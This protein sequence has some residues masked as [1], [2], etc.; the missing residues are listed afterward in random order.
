MK[1]FLKVKKNL[2]PIKDSTFFQS[3]LSLFVCK[4]VNACYIE[5][6]FKFAKN[7]N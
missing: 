5:Q 7:F 3:L 2:K 4:N 1:K 6:I